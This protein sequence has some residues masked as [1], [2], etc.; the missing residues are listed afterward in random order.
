M[1]ARTVIKLQTELK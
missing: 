1:T